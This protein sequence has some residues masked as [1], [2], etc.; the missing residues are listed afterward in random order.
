VARTEATEAGSNETTTCPYTNH[1]YW[2]YVDDQLLEVR[3]DA[4]KKNVTKDDQDKWMQRY[5]TRCLTFKLFY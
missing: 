2:N 3:E 1:Q 5:M 4:V